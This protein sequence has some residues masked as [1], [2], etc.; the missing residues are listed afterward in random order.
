MKTLNLVG[1]FMLSFISWA[2]Q[3]QETYQGKAYQA[4]PIPMVNGV[5]SEKSSTRDTLEMQSYDLRS[6]SI[7]TFSIDKNTL[8]QDESQI[9]EG[10][11]LRQTEIVLND[12]NELEKSFGGMTRITNAYAWPMCQNVKVFMTFKNGKRYVCSGTMIDAYHVLTAG[13]CVYG[14]E[15]GGFLTEATI[16]PSYPSSPILYGESRGS[17]VMTSTAWMNN[18]DFNYDYGVIRL[19]SPMGVYTGWHGFG[20]QTDAALKNSSF[21]NYSY[22][23]ETPYNGAAMYVRKGTFDRVYPELLYNRPGAYGGM[24]GSGVVLNNVSN[25]NFVVGVLSFG[26][27]DNAETGVVRISSSKFIAIRDYIIAPQKPD[28]IPN[29]IS[30][31]IRNLQAG[32]PVNTPL[33]LEFF[34]HSQSAFSGQIQVKFVLYRSRKVDGSAINLGTKNLN[35]SVGIKKFAQVILP[36]GSLDLPNNLGEGRYYLGFVLLTGDARTDNNTIQPIGLDEWNIEPAPFCANSKVLTDND[37]TFSDESDYANYAN[38]SN[39]TWIIQPPSAAFIELKFDQFSLAPDD[40]VKVYDGIGTN[41]NLLHSF[42]M[43]NL[44]KY[45]VARSGAMSIQFVSNGSNRGEGWQASYHVVKPATNGLTCMPIF[46]N[47]A[48]GNVSIRCQAENSIELFLYSPM[49]V[50]V[51]Y[52]KIE[53][54]N[55]DASLDLSG[56]PPGIYSLAILN[57]KSRE[58]QRV[59]VK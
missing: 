17:A 23:A 3:A 22:P 21:I 15:D 19:E 49:G 12:S 26:T 47:P 45:T 1:V 24:S 56:L 32:K 13:H 44:P 51:R 6:N 55:V 46:P 38:N 7:Y 33:R 30:G 8:S 36:K 42:S 28:L 5:L 31:D 9:L 4:M 37:G 20:T 11:T 35:I 58:V 54:G 52:L 57:G 2:A 41:A 27:N 14:K 18:R 59:V 29:T 10:L 40:L 25:Q 50:Q 48:Q 39:C 53:K 43:S 16:V 34:N